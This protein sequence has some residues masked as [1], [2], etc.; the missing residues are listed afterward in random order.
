MRKGS[1][2]LI[3]DNAVHRLTHSI[4]VVRVDEWPGIRR[5]AGEHRA[6]ELLSE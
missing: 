1:H 5:L 3:L 4:A 2:E 6:E